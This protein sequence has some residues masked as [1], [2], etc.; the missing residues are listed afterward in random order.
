MTQAIIRHI[1]DAHDRMFGDELPD[2]LWFCSLEAAIKAFDP[3]Q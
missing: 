1:P 3:F 2:V